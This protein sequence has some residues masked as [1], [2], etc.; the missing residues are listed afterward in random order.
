RQRRNSSSEKMRTGFSEP[1][2][3]SASMIAAKP[4]DTPVSTCVSGAPGVAASARTLCGV[5]TGGKTVNDVVNDSNGSSSMC[6][7]IRLSPAEQN[8]PPRTATIALPSGSSSTDM[9]LPVV[10][11]NGFGTYQVRLPL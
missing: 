4:L 7:V 2:V 6:A 10:T 1:F 3:N 5:G 11:V 8:G 9:P